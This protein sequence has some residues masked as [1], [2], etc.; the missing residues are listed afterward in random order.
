MGG[1][2]SGLLAEGMFLPALGRSA[3]VNDLKVPAPRSPA[4][5]EVYRAEGG[6]LGAGKVILAYPDTQARA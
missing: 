1:L 4:G 6:R 3:L 5:D 2:H